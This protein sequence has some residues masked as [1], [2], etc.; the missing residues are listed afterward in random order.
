MRAGGRVRASQCVSDEVQASG[1]GAAPDQDVRKTQEAAV[2]PLRPIS[3]A[4][5]LQMRQPCVQ[6]PSDGRFLPPRSLQS[7][8]PSLLRDSPAAGSGTS[9]HWS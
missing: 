2:L 5:V 9:S 7:S 6:A 8:G 3:T 1:P 4:T